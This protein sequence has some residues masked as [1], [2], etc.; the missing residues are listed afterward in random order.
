MSLAW[1]AGT[2]LADDPAIEPK[3]YE[4]PEILDLAVKFNPAIARA[5]AGIQQSQGQRITA[6]A[7]PNPTILG[8]TGG[9]AIRDPSTGTQVN[10]YL[11]TLNQPLEWLGKRSARKPEA[12][13]G[14]AG[15]VA[16]FAEAKLNLIAEVKVRDVSLGD[17]NGELVKVQNGLTEG[18]PVVVKEAF[19][20]KSQLQ[21]K[22]I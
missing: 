21:K 13:V 7:Y 14:I 11:F 2:T 20:L 5:E 17:S 4:L 15:A 12:E 1:T 19:L 10:E 6:G 16:G 18:E 9:G 3:L 8:Q 22:D